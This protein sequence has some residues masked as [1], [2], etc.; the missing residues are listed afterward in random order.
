MFPAQCSKVN[1]RL[2]EHRR[3]DVKVRKMQVIE[4]LAEGLKRELKVVIPA[5]DMKARLDERL[6][7]AKD[8]VRINGFRPGKVPVGHL[9]KMY[10][11]SIMADLVNELVREKPSEILSSRGEKSATQPAISMTEDE[12]EAEK[13]LSAESDFEFTVAY[14][15]I[16]AIE[17]KANDGIK[18]TREVVE[19]TED[20]INEQILKIA[21]SARTYE[22]KKGKAAE[23]TGSRFGPLHPRFRRPAGW[24]QGRRRKDHHRDVPC[25]L[26]GGEPCRQGSQLRHHRQG[27]CCRRSG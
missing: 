7:D 26:P 20:E 3:H 14:E 9:K 16:P 27:S 12:Q 17:L 11:K 4:T 23:G 2:S 24:R 19:V 21:E 8:K 15:I 6:V 1:Q 25:R 18:V 22:T 13:I 5:A 10:G